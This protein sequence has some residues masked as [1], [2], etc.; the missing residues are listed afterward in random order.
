[1]TYS[2]LLSLGEEDPSAGTVQYTQMAGFGRGGRWQGSSMMGPVGTEAYW[3][4]KGL[5]SDS[6]GRQMAH[7]FDFDAWQEERNQQMRRKKQKTS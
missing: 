7:Y 4:K 6:A 2:Q 1:M 5:A 3:Q